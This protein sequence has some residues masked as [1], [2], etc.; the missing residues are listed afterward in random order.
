MSLFVDGSISGIS[1][2]LAHDAALLRVASSEGVDIAAK[3]ELATAEL[4]IGIEEFLARRTGRPEGGPYPSRVTIEQVV[5]TA[6]LKHWHALR[7]L[8]L[9]YDDVSGNHV[10]SRYS[11]KQNDYSRRARWAEQSLYRTGVGLVYAPIRRADKPEVRVIPGPLPAATYCVQVVWRTQS[12]AG[13]APSEVLIVTLTENGTIGVRASG[14]PDGAAGFDVYA[15]GSAES[16]T[17]QNSG[18]TA[19]GDEWVLPAGG[20]VDGEGPAAGQSPDFYLH[21]DRILQRG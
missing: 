1:D 18:M 14:A 7:T 13:G 9:I 21:N 4:G 17:K 5:A 3:Q 12:G 15:G 10:G 8:A 11:S 2:L 20:L 16:V 6:P 19:A